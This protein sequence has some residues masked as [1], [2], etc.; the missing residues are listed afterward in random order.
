MKRSSLAVLGARPAIIG[1]YVLIFASGVS[2]QVGAP[3]PP[4]TQATP[5]PLSGRNG[6]GG[7]VTATEAP[8]P[9]TTPSVNP[10]NPAVSVQGAF[11]GSTPST[12]QFPFA[13]KLSFDDAIE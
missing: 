13:G 1:L 6:Q 8:V 7:G 3:P 12:M 11:A 2:A 9:S 10:L 5:L 4:P